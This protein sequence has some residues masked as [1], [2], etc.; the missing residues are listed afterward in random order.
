MADYEPKD[1]NDLS[2]QEL[3]DA[4]I[5]QNQKANFL[6]DRFQ[7]SLERSTVQFFQD[8]LTLTTMVQAQHMD[9]D[10][11]QTAK[12]NERITHQMEKLTALIIIDEESAP[13][14][15]N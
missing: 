9:G 14:T 10:T 1:A 7:E 8:M 4:L 12:F 13:N 6:I 2:R 11:S 15:T 3:I 5:E